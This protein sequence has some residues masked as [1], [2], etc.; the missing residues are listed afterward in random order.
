MIHGGRITTGV[1]LDALRGAIKNH[2]LNRVL[3]NG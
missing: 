2:I 3:L 1:K